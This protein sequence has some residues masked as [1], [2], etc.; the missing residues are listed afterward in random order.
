VHYDTEP[1]VHAILEAIELAS[2]CPECGRLS[3]QI[4][5]TADGCPYCGKNEAQHHNSRR[6]SLM[7][8]P[9]SS[10]KLL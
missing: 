9:G 5:L 2:A 8:N 4:L 1:L 10:K 3:L 6:H 7:L